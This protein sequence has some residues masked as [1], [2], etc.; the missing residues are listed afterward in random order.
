MEELA[1]EVGAIVVG[2][3]FLV[4]TKEPVKKIIKEYASLLVLESVDGEKKISKI[5]P[6]I[7]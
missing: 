3:Y 4:A 7:I 1:H 6:E 2:N 5:N